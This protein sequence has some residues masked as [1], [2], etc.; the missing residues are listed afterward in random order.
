MKKEKLDERVSLWRNDK[1]PYG[2]YYA[3]QNLSEIFPGADIQ[4]TKRSPDRFK[5]L[6]FGERVGSVIDDG[7]SV[8]E[9]GPS[10]ATR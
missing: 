4:V 8:H 6:N 9:T 10:R 3:Y 7:K 5:G 2:T 1:I